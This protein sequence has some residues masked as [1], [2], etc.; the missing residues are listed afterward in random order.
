M[1]RLAPVTV[2]IPAWQAGE[3]LAATLDSL[4]AQTT[5]PEAVVVV[6]D[7]S[8]DAT[9]HIAIEGGATLLRQ[10]HRGPGAARNRGVAHANSEFVAFLD[11]DDWYAPDKLERSVE[12]L[13]EIGA[14][15]LATDAWVVRGGRIDARKNQGRNVPTV[16]TTER[17]LKG[18]PVICSS[19]VARRRAVLEVGGFDEHPDLIAT[20]DFDLWLR[21]SEREPLA[22]LGEPLTFYRVHQGSL[23]ANERFLRGVDRILARVAQHHVGEAHFQNLIRRRRADVRL[24]YAWDLITT[25]RKAEGRA[26]IREAQRLAPTWKGVRMRLRSMLPA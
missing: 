15:C 10:D 17:L 5:P 22:Y 25:G 23:S 19:V 4:R 20:E 1:S 9:A 16:L 6:D 7:G 21:M 14:A 11:A 24:D 26:L 13:Q 8:T 2:V 12:V 18:S 3:F